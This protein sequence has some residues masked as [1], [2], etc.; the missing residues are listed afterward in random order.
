MCGLTRYLLPAFLVG[1]AAATVFANDAY[2][3]IAAGATVAIVA[4]VNKV[5]GTTSSCALVLPPAADAHPDGEDAPGAA[6]TS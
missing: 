6:R 2:G 1:L 5:R 4:A 3:W